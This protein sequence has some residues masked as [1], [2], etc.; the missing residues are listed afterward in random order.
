MVMQQLN[1]GP[2]RGGRGGRRERNNFCSPPPHPSRH[3]QALFRDLGE[4]ICR[5]MLTVS[6]TVY[7]YIKITAFKI[8]LLTKNKCIAVYRNVHKCSGH[9][10]LQV[11]ET[12]LNSFVVPHKFQMTHTQQLCPNSASLSACMGPIP[13]RS[14]FSDC[15]GKE[16]CSMRQ[17]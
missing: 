5:N 17:N 12:I 11:D 9:T 15:A 14:Y 16:N 8:A 4:K 1:L 10:F 6:L 3:Y 13:L 7:N 2:R